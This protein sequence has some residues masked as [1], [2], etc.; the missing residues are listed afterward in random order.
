MTLLFVA[1]HASAAVPGDIDL[2][3]PDMWLADHIAVDLGSADL[4]A[5]LA[6]AFDAPVILAEVSRLVI[7]MNRDPGSAGLIP[8]STDGRVVPGNVSLSAAQRQARIDRFH[9]PYHATIARQIGAQRPTLIVS[10]HSFTPRLASRDAPRPWPVGIL[11]N[12]DDR[13]ARAALR[14]LDQAGTNPGDNQPYSGR[15]LNYTMDRH[16]EA[17]GIPYLGLEVRQDQL[18][19][20]DDALH[21]AALLGAMIDAV[22]SGCDTS[23][24]GSTGPT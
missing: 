18:A 16:A 15:D 7:D 4:A 22:Q 23:Y 20:A 13:A 2:G 21:W 19:K 1:D 10:V 8:A 6:D 24:R 17:H 9:A 11:Y 12:R 14:W 5:A 3:I